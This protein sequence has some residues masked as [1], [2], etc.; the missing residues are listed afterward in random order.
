[1]PDEI[2]NDSTLQE[3]ELFSILLVK[4]AGEILRQYQP[5]KTEV[6]FKG[7]QKTDPVTMADLKI[8]EQIGNKIR[9]EYPDHSIIGEEGINKTH[10]I[11]DF[12]WVIDPLDGTAN[13]A[14]GFM[15]HGISIGLVY[16]GTPIIGSIYIPNEADTGTIFH[17]RTGGGAFS[18]TQRLDISHLDETKP[19]GLTGLP[20]MANRRFD[21][22]NAE[23]MSIGQIR[24][25]GSIVYEMILVSKG[26]LQLSIFG[27]P[28]IWDI[29]AGIVI[30]K[31]SGGEVFQWQGKSWEP[32]KKL[33]DQ[34]SPDSSLNTTK[35]IMIGSKQIVRNMSSIIV[36]KLSLMKRLTY[37]I[38]SILSFR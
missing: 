6:Q 24:I 5:G 2:P 23:S 31:E 3:L 35:P 11:K 28:H 7:K 22:K 32:L 15:L 33:L 26:V 16:K 17:A 20:Y 9:L 34:S 21:F 37:A 14:S 27:A 10:T 13:F 4:E 25:T 29:A 19:S 8:E 36:V 1:M 12:T 30:I 38:K 18:G